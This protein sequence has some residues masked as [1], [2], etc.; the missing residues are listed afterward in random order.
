MKH[1]GRQ[2]S[3][4]G[5]IVLDITLERIV[6]FLLL[7]YSIIDLPLKVGQNPF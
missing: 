3:K 6:K 1:K 5:R 7:T 4:T 2:S